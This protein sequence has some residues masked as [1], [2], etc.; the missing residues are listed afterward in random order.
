MPEIAYLGLLRR[1][2]FPEKAH[3]IPTA[4]H[5]R[6]LSHGRL[7]Q[8]APCS[9]I[10]LP[11]NHSSSHAVC[12]K[13]PCD[14]GKLPC[15]LPSLTRFWQA[16]AQPCQTAMPYVTLLCSFAKP[17]CD[18]GKLPCI[19]PASVRHRLIDPTPAAGKFLLRPCHAVF[20]F[21]ALIRHQIAVAQSH[22][23]L[24]ALS[25]L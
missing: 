3:G 10:K 4:R 11:G 1:S 9:L 17:P 8:N 21:F 20:E 2:I 6:Q 24:A 7:Q 19:L 16:P 18:F 12:Y 5:T 14:F 22:R 15:V 23:I 13:L 25:P